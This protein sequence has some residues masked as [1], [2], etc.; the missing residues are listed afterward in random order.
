MIKENLF[1]RIK[2]IHGMG[3]TIL[4]VEQDVSFAFDIATRNYVISRGKLVADGT[5][6]ELLEDEL[7]TKTYLGL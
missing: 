1:E 5:A 3:I 6:S 4:L 7:I 2:D